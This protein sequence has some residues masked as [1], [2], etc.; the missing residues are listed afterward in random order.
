VALG[1]AGA[2][3][4]PVHQVPADHRLPVR[5]DGPHTRQGKTHQRV[6]HG[7]MN[8]KCEITCFDMF[9][10]FSRMC[11][12]VLGTNRSFSG[13]QRIVQVG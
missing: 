13:Y 12:F 9:I 8:N 4:V 11:A 7:G 1:A 3:R 10:S 6:R 5:P 2:V